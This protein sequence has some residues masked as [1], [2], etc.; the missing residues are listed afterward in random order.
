MMTEPSEVND[1]QSQLT[2][3]LDPAVKFG[4]PYFERSDAVFHS[5]LGHQCASLHRGR[6]R[7]KPRPG[8]F[9]RRVIL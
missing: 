6:Y 2:D 9:S 4:T 5:R 3:P 7:Q 8:R 1:L